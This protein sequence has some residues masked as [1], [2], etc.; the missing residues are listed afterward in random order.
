MSIQ[1]QKAPIL[2]TENSR[3]GK[4]DNVKTSPERQVKARHIYIALFLIFGCFL[5]GMSRAEMSILLS[6]TETSE[7]G[8]PK[9]DIGMLADITVLR[10]TLSIPEP[11]IFKTPCA[12]SVISSEIVY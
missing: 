5:S 3:I 2:H 1:K 7:R 10:P 9:I 8:E 12:M 11:E 4:I 6:L